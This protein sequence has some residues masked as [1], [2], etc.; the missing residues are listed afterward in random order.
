MISVNLLR[1]L[2]TIIRFALVGGVVFLVHLAIAYALLHFFPTLPV[3][4]INTLAFCVAFQFS[5]LGHK[6]FTFKSDGSWRKFF[7]VAGVGLCVNNLTVSLGQIA[8]GIP[9]VAI[10]LGNVAAPVTV[11]FLSRFW[12]F[13]PRTVEKEG[14]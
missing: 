5:Y 11:F 13:A 14:A 6:F 12:A 7:F 1:E 8:L 4:V 10:I 9:F 2:S 3:L